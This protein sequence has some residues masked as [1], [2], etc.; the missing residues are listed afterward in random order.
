[1][2]KLRALRRKKRDEMRFSNLK[3]SKSIFFSFEV[4]GGFERDEILKAVWGATIYRGR[5]WGVNW[6]A[7]TGKKK[8]NHKK[9]GKL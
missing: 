1:M 2:I 5:G 8:K 3:S 4:M 7:L 9:L 6:G